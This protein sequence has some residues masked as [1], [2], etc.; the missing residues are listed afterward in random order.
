MGN[1]RGSFISVAVYTGDTCAGDSIDTL[2]NSGYGGACVAV[3][4]NKGENKFYVKAICYTDT[5]MSTSTFY[6]AT[7]STCTG[8]TAGPPEDDQDDVCDKG[9]LV[10]CH[11]DLLFAQKGYKG[12]TATFGYSDLQ[13]AETDN[14]M[15]ADYIQR[16]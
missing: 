11:A 5:G 12:R 16:E 15:N 4:T 14:I 9:V 7:D 3:R 8:P 1:V 10:N 2:Y 6:H 13:S